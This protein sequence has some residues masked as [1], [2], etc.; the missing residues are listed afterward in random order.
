MD[1]V[2]WKKSDFTASWACV[3]INDSLQIGAGTGFRTKIL[4]VLFCYRFSFQEL[5]SGLK[6][7]DL[8]PEAN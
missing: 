4:F 5:S 6:S 2:S 7:F 1:L 3:A 8:F